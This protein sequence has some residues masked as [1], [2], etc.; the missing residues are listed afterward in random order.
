MTA[1]EQWQHMWE[2]QQLPRTPG[3]A[4][5]PGWKTPMTPRTT[6]FTQLEGG[7]PEPKYVQHSS[8]I[9]EQDEWTSGGKDGRNITHEQELYPT[10]MQTHYPAP[11]QVYAQDEWMYDGKGKGTAV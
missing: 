9:H 6:A 8:P 4:T 3:T 5:G 7:K 10:H 11:A 1:E 2:L